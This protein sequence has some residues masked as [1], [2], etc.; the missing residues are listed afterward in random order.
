V[1][2]AAPHPGV[3]RLLW[4]LL[5]G[6]RT[7]EGSG[8]L[9]RT[10][11]ALPP[12]WRDAVRWVLRPKRRFLYGRLRAL[13]H[14]RVLSGPFAGMPL[15]GAPAAQ[16]LLGTYERE[17]AGVIEA[18]TAVPFERVINVGARNGYYAV[19]LARRMPSARVHAFEADSAARD[20]LAE[21]VALNGV[22]GRVEVAGECD[23]A[24]LA[25]SLGSGTGTLVVCDIDGGELRLLDPKSVP[26]LA[27]A[28]ILVE[29][30]R[31]V[32]PPTEPV[33]A[34]RFLRTHEVRRIAS[35]VRELTHLAPGVA[36]PW[37]SR[38]P[39]TVEA[40]MQEHRRTPQSWL[41]LTPR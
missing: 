30:H 40:L 5:T 37:R 4:E 20:V 16:E 9:L 32:A 18:L 15:A 17:L 3:P 12:A 7:V 27:R 10:F 26:A 2:P 29:C 25:A 33:M 13:A 6:Q 41:L 36:E 23:C 11:Q 24:A 31:H 39:A 19:G 21:A 1:T 28:T 14:D 35:E 22:A 34:A 8:P 38:M